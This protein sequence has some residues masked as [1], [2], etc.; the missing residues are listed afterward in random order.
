[1]KTSYD[2]LLPLILQDY[3]SHNSL[4]DLNNVNEQKDLGEWLKAV[5]KKHQ[6]DQKFTEL[7]SKRSEA[8][9][10][11]ASST[12]PQIVI[13]FLKESLRE[14]SNPTGR[15]WA[16]ITLGKIGGLEAKELLTKAQKIETN[17]LVLHGVLRG[18]EYLKELKGE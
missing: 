5:F 10:K 6:F 3:Q 14:L 13:S 17:D 8:L 15:L 9:L 4:E 16:Y 2:I 11:I 12:H 18:L 7:D 1:M